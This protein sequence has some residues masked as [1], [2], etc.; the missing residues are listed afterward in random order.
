[1]WINEDYKPQS[2][3]QPMRLPHFDIAK[4]FAHNFNHITHTFD[5]VYLL[6]VHAGLHTSSSPT[7]STTTSPVR[8]PNHHPSSGPDHPPNHPQNSSS[9]HHHT[10][11]RVPRLPPYTEVPRELDIPPDDISV[12][13]TQFCED[14]P[15]INMDELPPPPE[16]LLMDA[17][18]VKPGSCSTEPRPFCDSVSEPFSGKY[19]ALSFS[20]IS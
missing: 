13:D 11:Q 19:N 1:M 7:T 10:P 16:E 17:V 3:N 6:I 12:E 9:D 2:N 5:N 14:S 4:S 15:M 20:C 8:Y 18:Y